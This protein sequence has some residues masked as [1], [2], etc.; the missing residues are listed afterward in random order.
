MRWMIH[1]TASTRLCFLQVRR[2]FVSRRHL[3]FLFSLL[4]NRTTFIHYD[5]LMQLKTDQGNFGRF[6][7]S[8]RATSTVS[9]LSS[10]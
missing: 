5:S 9:G 8:Q 7:N 1:Y 3:G 4:E 10:T 2:T 6:Q